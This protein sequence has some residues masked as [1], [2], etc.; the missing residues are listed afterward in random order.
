MS[1][2]D[3]ER[4]LRATYNLTNDDVA[5]LL[6]EQDGRCAICLTAPA[7]HVDHD[8][9]TGKVRGMLCFPCNAALGQLDDDVAT[10]RRAADYLEGRKISMRRDHTGVVWITYPEEPAPA[11]LPPFEPSLPEVDIAAL[12]GDRPAE[13]GQ[14]VMT[15]RRRY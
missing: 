1:R 14:V 10:V 7:V 13:P 5:E 9:R 6:A 2:S 3:S 4:H 8:H 12:P 15:V 11:S